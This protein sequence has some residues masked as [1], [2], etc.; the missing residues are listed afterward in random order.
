M[1]TYDLLADLPLVVDS[2]ALEGL[3]RDVSSGFLR[4]TTVIHLHGGGEE[5]VGEDV[6]YDAEDHDALQAAGPSLD[7][8]GETTLGDFCERI[9][10]LDLF[11]AEPVRGEISRLY[12]RWAFHSAALDLA[13]RQAGRPLHDVLGRTPQPGRVRQ[14][15]A[16]RA[17]T[18]APPT[19]AE[20]ERLL[21]R[22]PTLRFKLD[23]T[24]AWDD[25][26]DRRRSSATGAIDS[27]DYKGHYKGTIVDNPADP[28]FYRRVAEALPGRLARGPR[29]RGGRH[30][31]GAGAAP[32]PHHVGRAD[33]L[34]RRHRGAAVRA[35]DGERQALALRRAAAPA[36]RATTT[37]PSTASARTAGGSSSSAPGAGRRS[38]SPRSSIR[39]TP[40][41][42]APGGYNETEPPDGL[43]ASPL[44]PRA[45]ARPAS[46]GRTDRGASRHAAAL[47]RACFRLACGAFL[48][49]RRSRRRSPAST[50][51]VRASRSRGCSDSP[52]CARRPR[53][54]RCCCRARA[55]ST[56]FGMRFALDL[57]WLDR[58]GRV[59][60]VDRAV[61]PRRVRALP[62]RARSSS[63]RR[64]PCDRHP[65]TAYCSADWRV[66]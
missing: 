38:T 10:A 33:P 27:L 12:R 43:P 41:D 3:A 62:R 4:K 53:G 32:R 64:A 66:D 58:D 30:R 55:R 47:R 25:A 21:E 23:P 44:E 56:R 6:V 46:A 22:Y 2:Y 7:L 63:C 17:S 35:A 28:V 34:D 19:R 37:A 18:T 61:P 26:L 48:R 8:A 29:P 16:P 36:A 54:P 5:G 1:G 59:V 51:A 57:V 45:V 42:L 65:G 60:R 9:D 20:I 39:D 49:R 40:N 50:S 31:R 11:P 52:G 24:P 15:A 14:L 13:L